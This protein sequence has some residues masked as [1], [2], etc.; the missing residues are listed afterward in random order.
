M[1]TLQEITIIEQVID[2][3]LF[4]VWSCI[5]GT[6]W[7]WTHLGGGAGLPPPSHSHTNVGKHST[8]AGGWQTS[9]IVVPV[10][11]F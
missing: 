4:P 1:P 9:P 3:G 11:R 7:V 8:N 6:S 2:L 5:E 10:R